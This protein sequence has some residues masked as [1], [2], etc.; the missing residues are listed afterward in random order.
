MQPVHLCGHRSRAFVQY[1][2]L[3]D[4]D[5][6]RPIQEPLGHRDV[7]TTMIYTHVLNRGGNGSTVRWTGSKPG[8]Q[9]HG[10]R[11]LDCT[12]LQSNPLTPTLKHDE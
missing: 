11:G 9:H 8:G 3:G 10:V 7:K 12:I 6:S 1:A 4:G 5:D 2:S